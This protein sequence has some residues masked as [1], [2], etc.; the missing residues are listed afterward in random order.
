MR[1]LNPSMLKSS[2]SIA[3]AISA[4]IIILLGLLAFSGWILD[5]YI[6]ASFNSK[7]VSL[8]PASAI[9]A[10]SFGLIFVYLIYNQHDIKKKTL[11]VIF[12][13]ILS[14]YA[15]ERFLEHFDRLNIGMIDLLFPDSLKF[16]N[17]SVNRMS[18]YS[19]L[20]FFISGLGIFIKIKFNEK[21]KVENLIGFMGVFL[22]FAGFIATLGY[23][24][25]TPLLYAGKFVPLS[26]PSAIIF[27]FL[28][29]GLISLAGEKSILLRNFSGNSASAKV[30]RLV[31]PII[32]TAILLDGLL[33]HKLNQMSINQA[34]PIVISTIIFIIIT[35]FLLIRLTKKIFKRA[36]EVEIEK[37][38]ALI[39]L[40]KSEQFNRRL[41]EHS[42]FGI[43]YVDA[44]GKIMYENPAL[45]AMLGTPH[46]TPSPVLGKI[47]W[48]LPTI[49]NAIEATAIQKVIDGQN[50]SNEIIHYQSLMNI[51][52][53]LEINTVPMLDNAEALEGTLIIITDITERKQADEQIIQSEKRAILQRKGISQ[54]IMDPSFV[55]VDF[56]NALRR[57]S[58]IISETLGV[59]RASIWQLND[60]HSELKCVSLYDVA[61]KSHTS[62][63]ILKPDV[64]PAYFK[65]I[66]KENRIYAEDVQN[67][68][69][70]C[71]LTESYL[72]PLGITS[73]LDGGIIIEGEIV[74]VICCEHI[75]PKRK[76]HSD[77]ESFVSSISAIV[78]QLFVNSDRTQ[79]EK[80]LLESE[81]K[82]TD[83]FEKSKDGNLILTADK[84]IECNQACLDMLRCKNKEK[85]LGM[86][87][88][89]ISPEFQP[90][91]KSSFEKANEMMNIAL[92]KGSHRFEWMHK[93]MNGEV[94]PAEVSLTTLNS[95]QKIIHSVVR[96]IS[97][98]KQAELER[99][100]LS[101]ITHGV[102]TTANLEELLSLINTS[103]STV[104]YAKNCF[105]ALYNDETGL[106]SFPYFIDKY[107]SWPEKLAM[108]KS[109][110]H[111]VF[112][113]QKSMIIPI[114]MLEELEKQNEVELVGSPSP[115]W[116]GVPLQTDSGVI[117]VLVLQ[118]YEKENAYTENH[119]RF[120][121]SIASQ[122]ANVIQR[123]RAEEELE[124]SV[125]L[126]NAAL[127]STADGIL[128]VDKNGEISNF[129]QRFIDL[130]Q[131]PPSVIETHDD[132]IL[133]SFVLD[134]LVDPDIFLNKVK[135]LYLNDE[136]T[137]FDI[138]EYK[139]GRIFERFS[140]AQRID[141]KVV[142]RVWSFHDITEIKQKE[143]E[144]K[145]SEEKFK[146]FFEKS[147]IGIEIYDEKGIQLGANMA[148][149]NMFGIEDISQVI[150]F[151]LFEGIS[152]S[153]ENKENLKNGAPIEY[154]AS[155]DFDKIAGLKQYKSKRK[156]KAEMHYTITPLKPTD[157]STVTGYLLLVQDITERK[158][159]VEALQKSE[160]RFRSIF[161][162]STL[163]IYRTSPE[164]EILLANPALI[165]MLEYNNFEE[166]IKRDL[167]KD[168][169]GPDYQRSDFRF[170]IE[171]EGVI[172][173]LES[174]WKRKDNSIIHVRESA[175]A[176]RDHNGQILFY[177]GIVEDITEIKQAMKTLKESEVRLKELNAT[178]DKFFSIIAH[179]LKSPFN[180]I[181]GFSN[182]LLEQIRS[183]DYEGIEKYST[184]IQHSSEKAMDLLSNLL[185]WSRSQT[186]RIEFSPE[187]I[188]MVALIDDVTDLLSIYAHQKSIEILKDLPHS[189]LVFADKAM[190][191]TVLRNIISNAIKFTNVGGE[192]IISTELKQNE[193][194]ISVRDNGIGLNKK[195]IEKLFRVDE[196]YSTP[197]TQNEKGTGLGLILCKEFVE[198][199]KGKIS[200]ETEL[201]KGSKFMFTIPR[202]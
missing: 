78:G 124:K 107:D 49:K 140:Q 152:L 77:E 191:S 83:L 65:A 178:K 158:K 167:E 59:E 18:P 157:L 47:I 14:I 161:E 52:K 10:I 44:F 15:F 176:F 199:H 98:Q 175:K 20:L 73:M 100:V 109:C 188:E 39:A 108:D 123:K 132:D 177:E 3:T 64:F 101:E 68:P 32:F 168:Y 182:L 145:E 106:Y 103:L 131:I 171:K 35:T 61:H 172:K 121:D 62:G 69:R 31:I 43:L 118:H 33:N 22:A 189:E 159:A 88:S 111:Y 166:L 154:I 173:G 11:L 24:F 58:E 74:G 169:Y 117:G 114:E 180:S 89:E 85:L 153:S 135:Y 193:T 202:I 23:L 87:P 81:Q 99:K 128:V 149:L 195:Q 192:I 92:K 201:G 142:G 55:E 170:Q 143:K 17:L 134:Q 136:E 80:E 97:N 138:L 115:S 190:I 183:K 42:P 79:A 21:Y 67:D 150:G 127:E 51:E 53:D 56:P 174:Q 163:G 179:D 7:Y 66:I 45:A 137:S 6:L 187:F 194:I 155:F 129:N 84:F 48:E 104:I 113:K 86:H 19:G 63:A 144:L 28:G 40:K 120:L 5:F 46:S 181:V 147:P 91:G 160:E 41:T 90:D 25:G 30:L 102:T 1:K 57:T 50:I 94:L 164:G 200:V 119:L 141:R 130:W 198:K 186:G 151:N 76:W 96:D 148:S 72:K 146:T 9:F 37:Q 162:N 197:G 122:V 36:R 70:T 8:A 54:L 2:Y 27:L 16:G 26:F 93:R 29:I 75:G 116:I 125:S 112:R 71:E 12:L 105:F 4:I 196:S 184:I 139:D 165:T 13:S 185:E 82:Y 156:G 95:E 126:L 60:D 38:N 110:T 34:L 133:L